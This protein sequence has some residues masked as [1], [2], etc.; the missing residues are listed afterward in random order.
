MGTETAVIERTAIE[1]LDP[2]QDKVMDAFMVSALDLEERAL[3]LQVVDFATADQ[4]TGMIG[5]VKQITDR[6]EKR[7]VEIV[8]PHNDY[9]KRVNNFAN[10]V[11]APLEAA[12]KTIRR[13]IL[14]WRQREEQKRKEEEARLRAIQ[15]EEQK[16]AE[17]QAEARGE[18]A[19]PP[20]MPIAAVE[21]LSK[22]MKGSMGGSAT[23]R[24]DW[25]FR[26]TDPNAV[27]REYMVVDEKKIR[28]LVKA[29]LRNISGVEIYEEETLAVRS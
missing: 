19:P 26:I 4:A 24:K 8:K 23:A 28:A 20:P 10:T 22:T 2:R 9:V 16:A 12:D 14:G 1:A 27:P 11:L 17:A 25:T 3:N 18:V 5:M 13:N 29:G 21:P 6:I 7:R 15:A